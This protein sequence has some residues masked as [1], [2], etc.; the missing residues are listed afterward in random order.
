MGESGGGAGEPT[1]PRGV[2]GIKVITG[3]A[4]FRKSMSE[5][6]DSVVFDFIDQLVINSRA[7][8]GWRSHFSQSPVDF[9]EVVHVPWVDLMIVWRLY[10]RRDLR[11]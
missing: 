4:S 10:D 1:E 9:F 3:S 7:M 11:R 8:T 5:D 2:G 6:D